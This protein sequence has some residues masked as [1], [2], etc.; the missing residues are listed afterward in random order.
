MLIKNLNKHVVIKKQELFNRRSSA[1]PA[2][3]LRAGQELKSFH[4]S[5]VKLV[6][7]KGR[8]ASA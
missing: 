8:F 5:G 6:P 3:F 1:M 2:Q 4:F 7:S